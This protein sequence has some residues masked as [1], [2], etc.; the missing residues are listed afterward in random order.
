MD[1]C[2]DCEWKDIFLGS[3]GFFSVD[4]N[5]LCNSGDSECESGWSNSVLL[6]DSLVGSTHGT[7]FARCQS[8]TKPRQ[9]YW[10]TGLFDIFMVTE[11]WIKFWWRDNTMAWFRKLFC[12]PPDSANELCAVPV[13]ETHEQ[14]NVCVYTLVS[15]RLILERNG[16]RAIT[17]RRAAS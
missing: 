2:L 7:V 4:N 11:V 9:L 6:G 3:V 1:E 12:D 8:V 13:Y 5:R 10:T 16:A 15:R 17:I 14:E